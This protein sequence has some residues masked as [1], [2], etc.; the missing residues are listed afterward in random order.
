MKEM[1]APAFRHII[2]C[3]TFHTSGNS[4][5]SETTRTETITFGSENSSAVFLLRILE[6]PVT[7]IHVQTANLTAG[8]QVFTACTALFSDSD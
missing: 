6:I 7:D 8:F 4:A 3:L 2:G 1:Q 5:A